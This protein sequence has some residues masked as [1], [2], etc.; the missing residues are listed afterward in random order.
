MGEFK[1]RRQ[2]QQ[3]LQISAFHRNLI[4]NIVCLC[5]LCG[6]VCP[7]SRNRARAAPGWISANCTTEK[8]RSSNLRERDSPAPWGSGTTLASVR[9]AILPNLA[10]NGEGNQT[11]LH[12]FTLVPRNENFY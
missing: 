1:L 8:T 4:F 2:A 5:Q 9:E 10:S 6:W 11:A 7:K 3:H 12:C